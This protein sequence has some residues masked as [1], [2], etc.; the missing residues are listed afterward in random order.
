MRPLE[1]DQCRLELGLDAAQQALDR[2]RR[3]DDLDRD[4]QLL[5]E[6]PRVLAEQ[7]SAGR[8][9]EHPLEN[10]CTLQLLPMRRLENPLVQGSAPVAG[11]VGE[12]ERAKDLLTLELHGNLNTRARPTM[13]PSRTATRLATTLPATLRVAGSQLPSSSNAWVSKANVEKVVKP[14]QNPTPKASRIASA[15]ATERWAKA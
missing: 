11:L 15:F 1:G 8:Q 6:A 4:G 9:S 13:M 14:P 2:G 10:G 5:G 3:V 12:S 7:G